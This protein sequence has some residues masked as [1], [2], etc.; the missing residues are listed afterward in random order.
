MVFSWLCTDFLVAE[1]RNGFN[2]QCETN[3]FSVFF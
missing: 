2:G 3:Y 1:E